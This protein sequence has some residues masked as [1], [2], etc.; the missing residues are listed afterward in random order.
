MQVE[1][2]GDQDEANQW[3]ELQKTLAQT[4]E[5]SEHETEQQEVE[6]KTYPIIFKNKNINYK[7][8]VENIS[9][10]CNLYR[11]LWKLSKNADIEKLLMSIPWKKK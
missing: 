10:D 4:N 3:N 6:V 7:Y 11:N 2:Q 5:E 1:V 9:N 8:L